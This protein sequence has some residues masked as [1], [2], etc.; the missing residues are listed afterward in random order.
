MTPTTTFCIDQDEIIDI[1][2]EAKA[3]VSTWHEL[4]VSANI[5]IFEMSYEESVSYFNCLENLE[6]IR[7]NDEPDPD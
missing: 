1:F 6:K 3:W 2:N 5:N 7:Q 4:M